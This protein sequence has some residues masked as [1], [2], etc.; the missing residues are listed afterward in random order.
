MADTSTATPAAEAAKTVTPAEV[1]KA[2]DAARSIDPGSAALKT[3]IGQ[4]PKREE[5][6]VEQTMADKMYGKDA[7]KEN[8]AKEPAKEPAKAEEQKTEPAKTEPV[9]AETKPAEKTAEIKYELK[10]PKDSLLDAAEVEKEAS[11]AKEKNLSPD[12]AQAV[13][14]RKAQAVKAYKEAQEANLKRISSE[15]WPEQLRSHPDFGGEKF[16]ETVELARRAFHSFASKEHIAEMDRTG[17]GNHPDHIMAWARVGRMIGDG[18]ILAGGR[19]AGQGP[20]TIAQR[21]YGGSDGVK[22]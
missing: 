15:V 16:N 9:K 3:L 18:K 6:K 21:I 14:E 17:L 12:V 13:L 8:Q 1:Q 7:A 22:K 5:P 11:F 19:P 4:P 20:K 2:D 10:L